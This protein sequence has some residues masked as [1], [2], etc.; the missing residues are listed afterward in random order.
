[1]AQ[2]RRPAL[3]DV[4]EQDYQ[5]WRRHPVS[6]QIFLWLA[7]YRDA[8]LR[9]AIRAFMAGDM[10]RLMLNEHRGRALMCSEMVALQWGDVIRW[11]YGDVK[12]PP[13]RV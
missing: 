4:S 12:P 8:F 5:L 11:Y 3:L 2:E 13:E 9:D 7:D 10:D 1:V 6:V